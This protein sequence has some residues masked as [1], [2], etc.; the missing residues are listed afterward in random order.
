MA[1]NLKEAFFFWNYC[2]L[3]CGRGTV[4]SSRGIFRRQVFDGLG[5]TSARAHARGFVRFGRLPVYECLCVCPAWSDG[6]LTDV[7][8]QQ[9][10]ALNSDSV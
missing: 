1:A 7:I 3:R 10:G 2:T 5:G 6:G 4:E 9:D 8:T